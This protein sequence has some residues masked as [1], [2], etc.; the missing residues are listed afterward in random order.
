MRDA[1]GQK[2]ETSILQG[3]RLL[4]TPKSD[5]ALEYIEHLVFGPVDVIL[6]LLSIPSDILQEGRAPA[7]SDLAGL[8]GEV[9]AEPIRPSVARSKS[10]GSNPRAGLVH[11]V[12]LT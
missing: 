4:T 6:R 10:V 8:H 12:L 7:A 1:A 9:D 11:R 2:D 5:R 3:K